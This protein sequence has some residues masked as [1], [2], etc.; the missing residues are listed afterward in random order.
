MDNAQV[1]L[2]VQFVE[3]PASQLA[4]TPPSD[5]TESIST[6]SAE[7]ETPPPV[8]PIELAATADPA[9]AGLYTATFVPRHT[10]GYLVTADVTDPKGVILGQAQA[11]WTS[12]PAAEE[13]KSLQPNRAL[14]ESIASRTGG[15]IIEAGELDS[16]A[17]GL[18]DRESPIMEAWSFP[19]WHQ[20]W[21]LLFALGCFVAEWG[22]RRW[23]GLA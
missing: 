1:K 17:A 15:E 18:P 4:L 12:D 20:A 5:S 3:A 10:G 13:F 14:L 22:L 19:L 23:N 6:A 21:V 9:E 2:K 7:E 11:G 8:A 16:F